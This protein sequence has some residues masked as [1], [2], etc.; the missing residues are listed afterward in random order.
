MK[1]EICECNCH[2]KNKN[3][4]HFMPCCPVSGEKYIN[5]D[6]SLDWL[7]LG[8]AMT[9]QHNIKI[10]YDDYKKLMNEYEYVDDE[11][12]KELFCDKHGVKL[13]ESTWGP[14]CPECRKENAMKRKL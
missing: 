12:L 7:K 2:I 9:K 10:Y 8:E 6:G 11:K 1:I 13:T 5:E 14:M 4:M 3:I